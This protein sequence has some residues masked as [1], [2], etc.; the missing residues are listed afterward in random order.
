MGLC[1]VA[2]ALE[3]SLAVPQL[4][5]CRITTLFSNSTPRYIPKRNENVATQKLALECL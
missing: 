2:P 4:I 1:Y 3:N 5:K